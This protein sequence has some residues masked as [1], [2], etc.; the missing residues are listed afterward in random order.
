MTPGLWPFDALARFSSVSPER[1]LGAASEFWKL[2][3][4]FLFPSL[5]DWLL[6][7]GQPTSDGN[8]NRTSTDALARRIGRNDRIERVAYSVKDRLLVASRP[9]PVVTRYYEPSMTMV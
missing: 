6:I 2:V 1:L 5:V 7:A 9:G 3:G 8:K 4:G